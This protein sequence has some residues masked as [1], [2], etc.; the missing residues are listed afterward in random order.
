MYATLIL[1]VLEMYSAGTLGT[2]T[3]ENQRSYMKIRTLCGR[4]PTEI[5]STCVKIYREHSM[6]TVHH[7]AV[8]Y[9]ATHFR[10]GHVSINDEPRPKTSTNEQCVRLVVDF[11]QEMACE[12]K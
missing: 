1:Q 9:W 2:V 4:N 7:S 10:D 6:Q 8:L 5:H 11:L 3:V 12:K